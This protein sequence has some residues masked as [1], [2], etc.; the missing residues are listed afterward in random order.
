MIRKSLEFAIFTRRDFNISTYGN[1][2]VEWKH[3]RTI[4]YTNN[5]HPTV[6]VFAN[7]FKNEYEHADLFN[8]PLR[9]IPP[10][11]VKHSKAR[12]HLRILPKSVIPTISRESVDCSV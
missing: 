5:D 12:R 8:L 1:S 7:P 11:D 6:I 4:R 3:M 2:P 9:V 10:K